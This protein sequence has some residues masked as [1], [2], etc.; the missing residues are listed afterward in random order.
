[1]LPTHR[2]RRSN[3]RL[4]KVLSLLTS[5]LLVVNPLA[6]STITAPNVAHA[7][8]RSGNGTSPV[9]PPPE[10]R[11]V[12]P[13]VDPRLPSLNI[14]MKVTPHVVAVGDILTVT[15]T[16]NNSA[17]NPANNLVVSLPIP[18]GTVAH[19]VPQPSGWSWQQSILGGPSRV[20][21]TATLRVAQMPPGTALRSPQPGLRVGREVVGGHWMRRRSRCGFGWMCVTATRLGGNCRMSG[22]CQINSCP[23]QLTLFA[24]PVPCSVQEFCDPRCDLVHAP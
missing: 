12:P 16:V 23:V 22:L 6:G 13:L 24:L 19:P 14:S 1:M 9:T 5:F 4:F 3:R 10:R 17:S 7:Q 8:P 21:L 20:T 18:E 15:L 2:T 11:T